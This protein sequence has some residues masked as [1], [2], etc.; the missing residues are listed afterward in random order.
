[1]AFSPGDQ[2]ASVV[3]GREPPAVAQC[4]ERRDRSVMVE[5][6]S[7]TRSG[8]PG[9]PRAGRTSNPAARVAASC[10]YRRISC[11][12]R[13][14][15]FPYI[16]GCHSAGLEAPAFGIES[17]QA[18]IEVTPQSVFPVETGGVAGESSRSEASLLEQL[19]H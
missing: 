8:I 2:P 13:A 15:E 14:I 7:G 4:G 6:A 12:I 19:I 18:F 16:T 11:R 5:D 3:G 9:Q 1:M 10:S 17:L